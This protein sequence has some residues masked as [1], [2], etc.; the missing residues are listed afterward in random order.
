MR[1]EKETARRRV[2]HVALIVL[3]ALLLLLSVLLGLDARGVHFYMTGEAE[4]TVPW[5]EAYEEPGVRAFS[6]GRLTGESSE[7]LPVHI[8]GSVDTGTMGDYELR[9]VA[10]TMFRRYSVRRLVHVADR[11][12]PVITLLQ[13]ADYTPNWLEGYRE[14]GYTALDDVD[15]DLTDRV[16]VEQQGDSRI[17][18]VTDSAGNTTR[19]VR[20]ISY[21]IGR[22]EIRLN[23]GGEMEIDAGFAFVDP[24]FVCTDARGNDLSALV[25]SEGEVIPYAAGEY[26]L[27]YSVTNA[28]GEREETTRRVSVRPLRNPDVV[29]PGGKLIYLSFD[30]GPSAETDRLLDV[31]ARY[32]V[33]ATFFVTGL[34]PDYLDC[35]GRA[36]RE[37]HSIGVHSLS[38]SY[39]RVY[40]SEEAFLADFRAMQ[41]EIRE[42]TGQESRI[43]RFPGG[44]SNTVSRF[45]R[46]I[47]SRLTA[48]MEEMGYTYFDWNVSAG[49]AEGT[50]STEQVLQNI[51][52]GCSARRVSLVLQHDNLAFSVDA[53][54]RVIVWGLTNG[55][56]FAALDETS[57]SAHHKLAN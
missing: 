12:A 8:E 16:H 33:K 48:M 11:T 23:G 24:G 36:Y 17:Y 53:V 31:L 34:Y 21:S 42:Q 41:E 52:D 6:V 51:I 44:S 29:D 55:Y 49:D 14:E 3:A 10:R 7:E 19:A 37:G 30:D 27:C 56:C 46:G 13:R 9:Y 18:T 2:G 57:P 5:G 43:F 38:H 20:A 35:I 54:E 4:I 32:N 45:N 22:P 15:G 26:V 39:R 40:A 50:I 1:P 28:L 47:M 25:V